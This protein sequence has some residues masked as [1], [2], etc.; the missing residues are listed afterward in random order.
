MITGLLRGEFE[1]G[2]VAEVGVDEAAA[3]G[4]L[5]FEG[6]FV[7]L[8]GGGGGAALGDTQL[9]DEWGVGRQGRDL[10]SELVDIHRA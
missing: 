7:A 1:V 2:G 5:V 6:A 8:V 9:E 3:E 4:E 10:G